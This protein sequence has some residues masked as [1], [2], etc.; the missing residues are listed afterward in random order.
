[1]IKSSEMFIVLINFQKKNVQIMDDFDIIILAASSSK[2][3]IESCTLLQE[4]STS[5]NPSLTVQNAT[6]QTKTGRRRTT[7]INQPESVIRPTSITPPPSGQL[8]PKSLLPIMGERTLLSNLLLTLTEAGVQSRHHIFIVVKKS[9]QALI[10]SQLDKIGRFS[11]AVTKKY[12][13]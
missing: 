6:V 8:L 7:S 12:K 4:D 2:Q 3:F 11:G 5:K 13:N 10:A 9:E 1:M